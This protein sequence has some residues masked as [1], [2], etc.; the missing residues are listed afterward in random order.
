M[1]DT[2]R[3]FLMQKILALWAVPR[4]TSTAFET[5]MRQ[6]GDFLVFHEPFGL[7][8]YCSEER[9]SD[10]YSDDNIQKSKNFQP[11]LQSLID[12]AQS[13]KTFMKDMAYCVCDR[14]DPTFLSHF[15]NTFLIRH[16]AKVL[17]S[18]FA[19]WPDFS[20]VEAGYAEIYHLFEATQN[21][22]G[23]VPPLID[24]DDLVH[25]PE[26]TVKAY[27]HAV[28]IPFLPQALTWEAKQQPELLQWESWHKQVQSSQGFKPT[29]PNNYVKI[30]DNDHL[31]QAYKYCLPYYEKLYEQRLR[32]D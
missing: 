16:P 1:A 30:E 21:Y 8:F 3:N 2:G 22:L 13:Q 19:H 29:K 20:L 15:E 28:G 23:K 24:S 12:K 27:C 14:A 26:A 17:P 9:K 32:I 10:R 5:M 25:K 7:C 18:L 4:S 6:R 11:L 31:Q